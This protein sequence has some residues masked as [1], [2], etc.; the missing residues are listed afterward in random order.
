[1]FSKTIVPMFDR[2]WLE[3]HQVSLRKVFYGFHIFLSQVIGGTKML[4]ERD[5]VEFQ[6]FRQMYRKESRAINVKL[7]EKAP[8]KIENGKVSCTN[9]FQSTGAHHTLLY[10]CIFFLTTLSLKIF[11]QFFCEGGVRSYFCFK[12]RYLF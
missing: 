2:P 3:V 4:D 12:C 10:E 11:K 1:M 7:L 6:V 8:E 5:L 9:L